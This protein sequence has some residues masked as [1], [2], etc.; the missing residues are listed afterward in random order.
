M[1]ISPAESVL[2]IEYGDVE[3]ARGVFDPPDLIFGPPSKEPRPGTWNLQSLPN[4]L[5]KNK[6]AAVTIGKTVGGS[7]SVNGMAFDR[8]S[9][10]DYD[11]WAEVSSPYFDDS[12][13]KWDWDGIFSYFK[14]VG[15]F[16]SEL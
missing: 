1:L 9:R 3:Y 11:A 12:E 2:V 16:K 6:T 8:P 10:F 14:K 5:M 4:P 7:S 13:H 15:M